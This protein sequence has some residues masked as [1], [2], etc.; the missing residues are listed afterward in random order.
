MSSPLFSNPRSFQGH[1]LF[2]MTSYSITRIQFW[3]YIRR[4]RRAFEH[5]QWY[6][7]SGTPLKCIPTPW[8]VRTETPSRPLPR[9]KARLGSPTERRAY[10]SS[11]GGRPDTTDRESWP[12]STQWFL[13]HWA[14]ATG[15]HRSQH[16]TRQDGRGRPLFVFGY[17]VEKGRVAG[18][19][20]VFL[21]EGAEL[22]M[23]ITRASLLAPCWLL[24][25]QPP[26]SPPLTAWP[27]VPPREPPDPP[28]LP[29]TARLWRRARRGGRRASPPTADGGLRT[30]PTTVARRRG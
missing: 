1:T 5:L 3:P 30:T 28:S 27:C 26:A 20:H 22:W 11:P 8:S 25:W 21:R 10:S 18:T 4:D 29:L 15:Y 7:S 13:G 14:P 12:H 16:G 17:E 24:A 2:S 6:Q 19:G 9:L 23:K